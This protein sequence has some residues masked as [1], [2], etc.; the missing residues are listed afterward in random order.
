MHYLYILIYLYYEWFRYL[1]IA[2]LHI[3]HEILLLYTIIIIIL[4]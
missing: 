2:K 3:S 1:L 4:H